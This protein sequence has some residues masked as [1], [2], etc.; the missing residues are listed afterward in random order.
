[1]S[2]GSDST[3]L[4]MALLFSAKALV[5]YGANHVSDFDLEG[6]FFGERS[7]YY[8]FGIHRLH[9]VRILTP[10]RASLVRKR[11]YDS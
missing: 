2:E 6:S 11:E 4:L 10:L 1:M 9:I 8:C 7:F 5:E 3:P